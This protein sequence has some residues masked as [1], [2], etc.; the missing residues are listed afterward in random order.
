MELE[1]SFIT[2]EATTEKIKKVRKNRKSNKAAIVRARDVCVDDSH[3]QPFNMTREKPPSGDHEWC[4]LCADGNG[5]WRT[6]RFWNRDA[7]YQNQRCCDD[8]NWIE[9]IS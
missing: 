7:P 1:G 2:A 9:T 6:G 5:A 4:V 3:E 8:C